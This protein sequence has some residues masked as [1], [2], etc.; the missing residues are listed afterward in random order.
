M[1]ATLH[2][3]NPVAHDRY[4]LADTERGVRV[5]AYQ[6]RGDEYVAGPFVLREHAN[7]WLQQRKRHAQNQVMAWLVGGFLV[8]LVLA[9]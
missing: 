7:Q 5:V 9:L 8:L 4:Y 1:T 6:P 2:A 3:L